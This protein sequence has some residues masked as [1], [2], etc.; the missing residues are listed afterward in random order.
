MVIQYGDKKV[1]LE[2]DG[3]RF[4]TSDNL[5]NDLARQAILERLG[6]RFIRIRGS[7]YY[8]YPEQT[9]KNVMNSLMKHGIH[10]SF[11]DIESDKKVNDE[12]LNIVKIKAS[13]YRNEVVEQIEHNESLEVIESKQTVD[14]MDQLTRMLDVHK[15]TLEYSEDEAVDVPICADKLEVEIK[16]EVAEPEPLM[17]N[18]QKVVINKVEQKI[19]KSEPAPTF[20]FR[21][22]QKAVIPIKEK[23]KAV[24]VKATEV[25]GLGKPKFD[26]RNGRS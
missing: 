6:W 3:E 17:V 4:H 5:N 22:K 16:E 20:D 8:R 19:E 25:T 18:D 11:E 7:E 21:G 9:M 13:A 15:D 12:L 2:C 1:A 14:L 26:F 10:P 24:N 23:P